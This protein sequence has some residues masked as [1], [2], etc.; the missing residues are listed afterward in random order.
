MNLPNRWKIAQHF[1]IRW[2]RKYLKHKEPDDY[3]SSKKIYWSFFL[4]QLKTNLDV[5]QDKQIL[6]VGAGPAGI[7]ILWDHIKITAIDPLF[8]EYEKH[9]PHF[10][11]Q[12]Y[13]NVNFYT[14]PF[15]EFTSESKYD[16]IFCLNALNHFIDVESS[17]Q[18]LAALLVPKGFLI[19]SVDTHSKMFFRPIFNALQFDILHPHQFG[20]NEFLDT[21]KKIEDFEICEVVLSKGGFLFNL[22]TIVVKKKNESP[23]RSLDHTS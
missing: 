7:F 9:L 10:S 15:E 22:H 23:Q 17:L 18:K 1:E 4:G 16:L 20:L 3:L 14:T 13:K 11:K 8:D 6:D 12:R 21:L 2:W 5:S 19:I